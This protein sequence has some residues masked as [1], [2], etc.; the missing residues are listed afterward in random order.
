MASGAA[1]VRSRAAA[2]MDRVRGTAVAH[3]VLINPTAF[4]G[5]TPIT[6]EEDLFVGR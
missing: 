3:L 5:P 6:Y 1:C 2:V 4:P